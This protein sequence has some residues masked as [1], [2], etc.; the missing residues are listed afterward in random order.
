MP[1]KR[2]IEVGKV[3]EG[4]LEARRRRVLETYLSQ[5]RGEVVR[6][7]S[8]TVDGKDGFE[9]TCKLASFRRWVTGVDRTDG[10]PYSYQKKAAIGRKIRERRMAQGL[11]PR[12]GIPL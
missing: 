7:V 3:Y 6:F 2:K 8:V 12:F 9:A 5:S 11:P 10:K 1:N 4:G